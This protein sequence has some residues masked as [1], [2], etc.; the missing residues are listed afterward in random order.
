MRQKIRRRK[1]KVFSIL[2]DWQS[3]RTKTISNK[4]HFVQGRPLRTKAQESLLTRIFCTRRYLNFYIH[5]PRNH[6]VQRPFRTKTQLS[7]FFIWVFRLS[8]VF[9]QHI[10]LIWYNIDFYTFTM[11]KKKTTQRLCVREYLYNFTMTK[12]P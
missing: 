8:T 5:T 4:D 12:I 10:A 2:T 11:T 6:F 7:Q 9:F 1:S 3:L